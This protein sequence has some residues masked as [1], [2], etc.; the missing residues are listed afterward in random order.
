MFG[1]KKAQDGGREPGKRKGAELMNQMGFSGIPGIGDVDGVG[2]GNDDDD[3]DDDDLEAELAQLAG[4]D[5][6]PAKKSKPKKKGHLPITDIEKLAAAGLR[7]ID[8]NVSDTDDPDLLAELEDLQDDND[9]DQGPHYQ[10][11]SPQKVVSPPEIS[12][13]PTLPSVAPRTQTVPQAAHPTAAPRPAP[14]SSTAQLA[15]TPAARQPASTSPKPP[16]G[17][18]GSAGGLV[19]L[20]EE[21]VN[22]YKQAIAAAKTA[23]DSAK[24]RRLDRGLKTLTDQLRQAK[25]GKPVNEEEIPPPVAM[26]T[27]VALEQP[28]TSAES[29]PK[30]NSSDLKPAISNSSISSVSSQSA[31]NSDTK[32][33]LLSRRD[34]YRKAAFKA[35]QDGDMSKASSLVKVAKQFD[36]VIQA[37]EEGKPV[38]LSKMPPSPS[39]SASTVIQ[40]SSKPQSVTPVQRISVQAAG[41]DAE[42]EIP[43]ISSEQEKALFHAPDAPKSVM[44]ALTQRLEKYKSSEAAAKTEGDSGKARRMGRIVKQYEDAIKLYR[45]GKPVDFDEL[46]TP[47]GYG[48]IPQDKSPVSATAARPAPAAMAPPVAQ[49]PLAPPVAQKPAVSSAPQLAPKSGNPQGPS[50]SQTPAPSTSAPPSI[51][52]QNTTRKSLHSRGEQQLAFLQDRMAEFKQAAMN[53]KKNHDIELAKKYIRMMKG[54]EPMIEACESGLPVDLSQVPPSPA[55]IDDGE[56]KFVVVSAEDCEPTGDRDEVFKNLQADLV[57]QIRICVTNAQHYQKLGDVPAAARYEKLEQ[58]CRRDLDALKNCE[59]HG[60]PVP[61]FHYETKTFSMVQCN[62]ELGDGD[63]ELTIIRGIQYNIPSG[64]SEKD[65][66]TSV[67]YEMAFPTEQPQT[68]GTATVKDTIN[69]EYNESFKLQINRK[70]K[71]LYRFVERKSIK[72]DVFL[73]RGFFKGEKLL[74]TANIKLQPLENQCTIH[75]SFDLMEGRK[76]V[77]GKLEVKVRIRDPFKNKQVDEVKEK[78][79]VIDQFIRTLGSKSQADVKAQKTQSFPGLFYQHCPGTLCMEVLRL[80]KQMLDKQILQLKDSLSLTQKQALKNKS[81]L[82]QEKIDL[83]EKKLREGGTEAW[84]VYYASVQKEKLGFEMEARQLLKIGDTQKAEVLVN[85]KRFAEKELAAIKAKI[86]DV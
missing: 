40:T 78:W 38:D 48:P 13:K 21:R 59:R 53:A 65:M 68:G 75:E 57:R 62:T 85:K 34:E 27:S 84:K 60:D 56:D 20:L 63:L 76:S 28:T 72:L 55:G 29:V 86:P 45:A 43:V 19:G 18:S 9:E 39:D 52:R 1:K 79:L 58:N 44:E 70:S 37:F 69:P 6:S 15:P 16:V 82:I 64:L 2:Y 41:E 50:A 14:A 4:E 17:A 81:A 36:S 31:I 5:Y 25:A 10:N 42:P 83:Q 30:S 24:Q 77:G 54:I 51:Q 35:K 66:D 23:G 22:M 26:G 3:D 67:K 7:D 8:D 12:P 49:K 11:T 73:K 61:K 80:E 46:P 32:Q 74:G 33:I 71:G 47:P